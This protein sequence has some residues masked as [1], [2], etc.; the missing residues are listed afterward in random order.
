MD[1]TV[2]WSCDQYYFEYEDKISTHASVILAKS[3]KMGRD[4]QYT[5]TC[6]HVYLHDP[7]GFT[8]G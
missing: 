3:M 5:C 8:L 6:V 7:S 1:Y 2:P 4:M